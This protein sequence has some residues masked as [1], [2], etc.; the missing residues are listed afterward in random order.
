MKLFLKEQL[1]YIIIHLL[2]TGLIILIFQLDVMNYNL[3]ISAGSAGYIF[4]LSLVLLLSYLVIRYLRQVES[5][6]RLE[7]DAASLDDSLAELSGSP[8]LE[9]FT[10]KL[11]DQ[12][13]LYTMNLVDA[14]KKNE[15]HSTFIN[16]WV[17][18]MKT[19]ISV[20]E[21]LLQKEEYNQVGGSSLAS[22]IRE[23]LDRLQN[24][25][26]LAL[27]AARLDQ[28]EQDFHV[29]RISLMDT[30]RAAVSRHKKSFIRNKTIPQMQMEAEF[31]VESDSKWLHF[32][33]DQLITNAIK[34]SAKCGEKIIFSA[35]RTGSDVHF[36]VRDY[37]VGIP[38]QDIGRVFEPFFTGLNGRK[39][40]ESTGMGLYLVKQ[41]CDRLG[42]TVS[43]QSEEGQGTTF[44]IIFHNVT[45]L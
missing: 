34:Y 3:K 38:P 16:Q 41:I 19:P 35:L 11:K 31:I 2:N 15:E 36:S 45:K 17:H 40:Q 29:S 22:N 26:D 44:T 14:K 12:Y 39:F 7:K 43:I 30:A 23:E 1:S 27:H 25:L 4:I 9:Q 8:L 6:R 5:Y 18:Q 33:M 24:G 37:G 32:V 10:I 28:F 42:H 20:I 13:E 21:L